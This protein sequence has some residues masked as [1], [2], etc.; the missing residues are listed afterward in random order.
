MEA[1]EMRGN[2]LISLLCLILV[3]STTPLHAQQKPVYGGS[4]TIAQAVEPPG[5]DP[6]TATSAAIPRV[7]YSNVVEG[8]VK[9]R[10]EWKDFTALAKDYKISND[11]KE[12]TFILK[13]GVTFHDG[14]PFDAEDVKFTFGGL[15]DARRQAQFILSIIKR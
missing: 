6:T 10:S 11:G 14:K 2:L 3:L 8:L 9:D 15:M 13:K 5:L 12:Y 7:V 1:H 4:L